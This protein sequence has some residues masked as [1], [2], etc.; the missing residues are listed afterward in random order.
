MDNLDYHV[1]IPLDEYDRMKSIIDVVQ[2]IQTEAVSIFWRNTE[3]LATKTPGSIAWRKLVSALAAQGE[4][5]ANP[6]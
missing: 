5:N 4:L 1:L 3:M 6:D 2:I